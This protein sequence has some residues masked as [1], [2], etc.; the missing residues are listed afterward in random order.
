[1]LRDTTPAHKGLA[2]SEKI[3]LLFATY[4]KFNFKFGI[5]KELTTSARCSCRAHTSAK[6]QAATQAKYAFVPPAPY[7]P[8]WAIPHI[9]KQLIT[10]VANGK[11]FEDDNEYICATLCKAGFKSVAFKHERNP[12]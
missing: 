1:M 7:L 11:R 8:L 2:P 3:H 12:G 6:S 4:S 5:F 10:Y 9:K